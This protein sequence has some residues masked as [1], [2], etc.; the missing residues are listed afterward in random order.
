V[1]PAVERAYAHCL[2][3]ARSHYEN[4]PVASV[5][6][7]RRLRGPVAAVYA[8]ARTADDFADEG[9]LAPAERLAALERY[10]A[11]LGMAAKGCPP[12]DE[13][14]FIALADLIPRFQVPAALFADLLSAFR[15]DVT[16]RRYARFDDLL[17]YCRRSAD[18]VGRILL[19]LHGAATAPNLPLSD[20]VCT[21]L[22]LINFLQDIAQDF[23]ENDRIYLPQDEMAACGVSE[24]HIRERRNDPPMR[25]LFLQQVAR[26]RQIMWQGAPLGRHLRGRFG[27]E[28]RMV[29]SGGL[30]VLDRL[31]AA[32]DLFARPRLR[33]RDVAGMI[34]RSLLRPRS[35]PGAAPRAGAA[36]R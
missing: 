30:A 8:F 12:D 23:N 11:L 3:R 16:C 18:P 27:L 35:F 15:Q 5:I 9:D 28:I 20:R 36:V 33:R 32:P 7:P 17:D 26:N 25:A 22:Q 13:P 6:L 1:S 2:S 10:E 14:V 24:R 21:A 34:L 31:E 29:I 4:F 19:H